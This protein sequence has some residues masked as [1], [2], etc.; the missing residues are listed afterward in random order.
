LPGSTACYATGGGALAYFAFTF[1]V[2][3][4]FRQGI[5][6]AGGLCQY[7]ESPLRLTGIEPF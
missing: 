1:G 3:P 6:I 4:F 5:E 7:L 2:I